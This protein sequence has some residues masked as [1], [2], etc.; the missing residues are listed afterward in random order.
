[1]AEPSLPNLEGRDMFNNQADDPRLRGGLSTQVATA[2]GSGSSGSSQTEIKESVD[3]DPNQELIAETVAKFL[4]A[5]NFKKSA[6]M[7]VV[8]DRATVVGSGTGVW[9]H[10]LINLCLLDSRL[11]QLQPLE[12]WP[13]ARLAF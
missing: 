10:F 12:L 3:R 8:F 2:P 9:D 4:K 7:N 11:K 13:R 5:W 6:G 1:M